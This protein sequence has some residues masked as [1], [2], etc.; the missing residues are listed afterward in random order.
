MQIQSAAMQ[1]TQDYRRFTID[2]RVPMCLFNVLRNLRIKMPKALVYTYVYNRP[3]HLRS[4]CHSLII[5][6]EGGRGY[7]LI[8]RSREAL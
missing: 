3:P 5:K 4:V 1:H 6:E 7:Y 8:E 2:V